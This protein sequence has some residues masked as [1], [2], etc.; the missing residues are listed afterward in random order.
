MNNLRLKD[1]GAAARVHRMER[2]VLAAE[3]IVN[4][5]QRRP[6]VIRALNMDRR[7]NLTL[8]GP[9]P[10]LCAGQN[11]PGP[12]PVLSFAGLTRADG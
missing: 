4:V 10:V 8:E 7:A 3:Q 9:Q 5:R 11:D 12:R 6:E 2:L 1:A